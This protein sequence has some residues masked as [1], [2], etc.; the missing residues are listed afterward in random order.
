MLAMNFEQID[1]DFNEV[2]NIDQTFFRSVETP[3][4]LTDSSKYANEF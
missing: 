1:S 4:L 3:I 2:F